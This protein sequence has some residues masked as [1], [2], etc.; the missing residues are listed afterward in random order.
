MSKLFGI[1]GLDDEKRLPRNVAKSVD[2]I[3]HTEA[4]R[5]ASFIFW[6][7]LVFYIFFSAVS[8]IDSLAFEFS[9]LIGEY[10]IFYKKDLD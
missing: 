4:L 1:N 7:Y 6:M 9:S 3:G 5:E 2:S 10:L 8:K